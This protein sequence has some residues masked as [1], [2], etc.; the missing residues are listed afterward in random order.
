MA[1]KLEKTVLGEIWSSNEA[2]E[3]LIHLCDEFG[4]RFPG[5]EGEKPSAEYIASKLREYGL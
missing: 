5:T 3:T 1:S 2:Y 4:S